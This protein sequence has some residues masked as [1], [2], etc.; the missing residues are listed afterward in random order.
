MENR[1]LLTPII[2]CL[3]SLEMVL[4]CTGNGGGVIFIEHFYLWRFNCF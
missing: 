3:Q 2:L 4:N 1:N